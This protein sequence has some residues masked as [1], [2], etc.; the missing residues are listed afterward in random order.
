[1]KENPKGTLIDMFKGFADA[2]TII[3]IYEGLE[4]DFEKALERCFELFNEDADMAE[5]VS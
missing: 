1:M 2:E 5:T 4:K 3:A